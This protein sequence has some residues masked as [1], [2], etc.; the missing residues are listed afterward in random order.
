VAAAGLSILKVAAARFMRG[1]KRSESPVATMAK[2]GEEKQVAA[3]E[4]SEPADPSEPPPQP[5]EQKRI[6]DYFRYQTLPWWV[7]YI[8]GIFLLTKL[9][10]V[11]NDSP[12]AVLGTP[13]PVGMS[14][15]KKAF[16][17]LSLCTHPDRLR[18][19]LKRQPTASEERRGEIIFNRASQAKDELTNMMK[20][21]KDKKVQCYQGELEMALLQIVTQAGK[22][23]GQLGISD[24]FSMGMDLFWNI[25]TFEAGFLNTCLSML[26]LA[27]LF[28]IAK[29]FFMYLWSMG[30]L[31]GI[32]ALLTTVIIGPIP[33]LLNLVFTPFLRMAV[34]L[35]S[36]WKEL[37]PDDE[38]NKKDDGD[39]AQKENGS[40]PAPPQ[41]TAAMRAAAAANK[42]LPNRGIRQRKKK[43][44]E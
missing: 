26:W 7:C 18:G 38:D 17:T 6:R 23:M 4:A 5:A 33:T 25:V 44:S 42:E 8:V 3:P 20:G 16:R 35:K 29:Q 15:V 40:E 27:F 41:L 39:D 14:D 36:L 28:R 9:Q 11:Y 30:I 19:R 13:S 37:R 10:I 1:G 12:C 2:T 31:R 43:E 24:Y 32:V 34:F 22:A 21:K